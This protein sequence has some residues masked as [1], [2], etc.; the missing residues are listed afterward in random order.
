M[1]YKTLSK[2]YYRDKELPGKKA[3]ALRY[4]PEGGGF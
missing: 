1:N 3:A 4:V 2:L